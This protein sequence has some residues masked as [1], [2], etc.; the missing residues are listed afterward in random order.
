MRRPPLFT[1]LACALLLGAL[2]ACNDDPTS[3]GLDPGGFQG[4]TPVSVDLEPSVFEAAT[5][6]DVTGNSARILTGRV[7]DPAVGDIETTGYIDF[8]PPSE[9]PDGFEGSDVENVRLVLNPRDT[10]SANITVPQYVYGD[11]LTTMTVGI[12][13]MPTEWDDVTTSDEMLTAGALITESAPFT[14]GDTVRVDL[15]SSGWE[16]FDTLSDTSAVNSDFHGFQIRMMAGNAVVGFARPSSL[17]EVTAGGE[18]VEYAATESF[19][20]VRQLNAPS[21]PDRILAQDGIGRALSLEFTLPDSLE[22]SPISRAVLQLPT[23]TTLF[24]AAATPDG[25]VRPRADE[26]FLQGFTGDGTLQFSAVIPL[27]EQ[28]VLSFEAIP[29]QDIFLQQ[30]FQAIALGESSVE[31]YRVS[32]SQASNTINPLLFYAPG[33]AGNTPRVSL[34]VTQSND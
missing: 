15:P 26:L 13:A 2:S 10:T 27:S 8:S 25:F 31:R 28:G 19:S 20:T 18:T 5:I 14:P 1:L 11:T 29:Q 24:D 9:L 3:V 4:G 34:T 33:I 30:F 21:V 7:D 22:G 32:L 17:L 16:A 6:D 23:D 12:Y